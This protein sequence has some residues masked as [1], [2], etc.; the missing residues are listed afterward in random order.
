MYNIVNN[1]QGLILELG[2][3]NVILGQSEK[4][5]GRPFANTSYR[6]GLSKFM[7]E[8]EMVDIGYFGPKYT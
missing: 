7:K 8:N 2:D 1:F 6:N 5:G 3:F 4:Y